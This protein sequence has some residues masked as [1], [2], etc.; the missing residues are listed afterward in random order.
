VLKS[1]VEQDATM[2]DFYTEWDRYAVSVI[3]KEEYRSYLNS[4][5]EDDRKLL[6]AKMNYYQIDLSS[7]GELVM[8]VILQ[9][10]YADGTKEEHRIPAEIWRMND[11]AVSKVFMS[12]K[13]LVRVVLDP[14][15]ET[16]DVDRANNAWPPQA[17]PTRFQIFKQNQREVENPMQRDRRA[18]GG[19]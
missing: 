13:E 8:P 11:K 10:E 5:S 4:L 18:K 2:R 17:E 3:D 15:L 16:A 9:L 7:P 1:V 19:K 14:H 6:D 12:T